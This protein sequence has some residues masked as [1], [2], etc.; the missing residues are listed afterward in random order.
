LDRA[1]LQD[2]VIVFA[3]QAPGEHP[4][5]VKVTDMSE[6]FNKPFR[7]IRIIKA[8]LPAGDAAIWV[9]SGSGN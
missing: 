6:F 5:V 4:S 2:E 9:A 8:K 7:F 3:H 1:R